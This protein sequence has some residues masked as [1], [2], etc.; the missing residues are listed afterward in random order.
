MR[1]NFISRLHLG[2]R[3]VVVPSG[4]PTE[5]LY[6]FIISAMCAP[7]PAHLVRLDFLTLIMY[8]EEHKL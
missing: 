2:V 8:V 1:F 7:Y 6:A 3:S 4:F 5:I